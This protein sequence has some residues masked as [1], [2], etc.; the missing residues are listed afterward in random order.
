MGKKIDN[1]LRLQYAI[2]G[3][4]VIV[5]F[6]A[7]SFTYPPIDEGMHL[8]NALRIVRGEKIYGDFYSYLTPLTYYLGAIFYTFDNNFLS[9]RVLNLVLT[10][11]SIPIFINYAKNLNITGKN[12]LYVTLLYLACILPAGFVFSHHSLSNFLFLLLLFI[13]TREGYFDEKKSEWLIS[14]SILLGA[15]VSSI[16]LTHQAHG[17]YVFIGMIVYLLLWRKWWFT[18]IYIS[19]VSVVFLFF[20]SV[21]YLTDR[22]DN[23]FYGAI[24]WNIEVYSKYLSYNPY[25]E[26]Y[27]IIKTLPIFSLSILESLLVSFSK[28][29]IFIFFSYIFYNRN[30]VAE[31]SFVAAILIVFY[32]FG[33]IQ[34][35]N[36]IS[37]YQIIGVSIPILIQIIK[38][39][40]ILYVGIL[41]LLSVQIL[42]TSTYPFR[43]F[44]KF[45]E[46]GLCKVERIELICSSDVKSMIE[47]N[48]YIKSNKIIIS[49]VIGRSPALYGFL[50]IVNVT[51]HD[52]IYPVFTEDVKLETILTKVNGKY[53]I[54]DFTDDIILNSKEHSEVMAYHPRLEQFL[55]WRG[56]YEIK[57]GIIYQNEKFGIAHIS[58]H[59]EQ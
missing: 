50:D 13:C 45:N 38:F 44:F 28:L 3:A 12:I 53:V 2:T 49:T 34:T 42:R 59:K 47:L 22:F 27:Y 25:S 46:Y 35:A 14:N 5:I 52:L 33:N 18:I 11:V 4:F 43:Q 31:K 16:A 21:L 30:L 24:Y 58:S 10:L 55:A 48:D 19:T 15:V 54:T 20:F 51:M 6:Y 39:K 57:K 36:S 29:G 37:F 17:F 7:F 56:Y 32:F 41:I 9:A 26:Q 23:F 1:S 40:R 8:Y